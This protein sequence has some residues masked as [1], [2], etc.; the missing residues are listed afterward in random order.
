LTR[1]RAARALA[2]VSPRSP[3]VSV[4]DLQARKVDLRK[5]EALAVHVL[6]AEGRPDAALSVTLVDDEA[7]AELHARYSKVEGPT[8][9][10]AFPLEDGDGPGLLGEV[11]VSTDTAA[12]EARARKLPFLRELLLYVAHGTLHLLGHDDHDP[13]ARRRMHRRQAAL[14]A[15]FLSTKR[16]RGRV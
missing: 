5:V 11:V 12:R 15:A 4:A 10:L 9:V 2:P 16:A 7:M 1:R 8:D 3:T 14:L 6:I 13:L